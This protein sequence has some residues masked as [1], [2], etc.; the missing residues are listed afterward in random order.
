MNTRPISSARD[1]DLRFSLI[2]L[3]R[4]VRR[5]HEVAAQ[6]Q[7]TIVISRNGIIEHIAPQLPARTAYVQEPARTY[8]LGE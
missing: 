3:Q 2:A 7:T 5:A 4:A 1:T 8:E 6:T